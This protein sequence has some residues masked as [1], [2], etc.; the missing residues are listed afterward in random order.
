MTGLGKWS[1]RPARTTKDIWD[2]NPKNDISKFWDLDFLHLLQGKVEL[3]NHRNTDMK[4][5][6]S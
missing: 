5:Q 3:W 1:K 4:L 2:N 6:I